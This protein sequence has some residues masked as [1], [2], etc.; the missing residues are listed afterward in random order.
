MKNKP[1]NVD[2]DFDKTSGEGGE[3]ILVSDVSMAGD[4]GIVFV[5]ACKS[6]TEVK[7]DNVSSCD[8]RVGW[9]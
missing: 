2:K 7:R 3:R 1:P 5:F 4:G 8:T 9:L 6:D